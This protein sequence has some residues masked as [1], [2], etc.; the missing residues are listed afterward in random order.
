MSKRTR[1]RVIMAGLFCIGV[2]TGGVGTGIAFAD[3]SGFSYQAVTSP[4]DSFKTELFTYQFT[5]EEIG[6][7]WADRFLGGE[8]CVIR[9]LEDIPKDTVEIAVTYNSEL[10]SPVMIAQKDDEGDLR[11]RLNL[12]CFD[13]GMEH[14]MKYKDQILAGLKERELRDYQEEFVKSVEYRVNPENYSRIQMD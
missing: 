11:I 12:E 6:Q 9:R 4:E 7:I 1:L 3:F 14:F 13:N 5:P 10:C 8:P 2:L